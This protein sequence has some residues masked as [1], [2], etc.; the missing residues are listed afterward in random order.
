MALNVSSQRA[1]QTAKQTIR[2]EHVVRFSQVKRLQRFDLFVNIALG[3]RK[4][5]SIGD[6]V[7]LCEATLQYC[8]LCIFAL[9]VLMMMMVIV[10]HCQSGIWLQMRTVKGTV[11]AVL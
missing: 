11:S 7:T 9:F 1:G 8:T 6:Q 10:I 2:T 3:M 5:W 4:C